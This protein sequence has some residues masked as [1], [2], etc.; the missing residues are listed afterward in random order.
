MKTNGGSG[1]IDHVFLTSGTSWRWVVSFTPRPLY[2][3]ER[4]SRT[5]WIGGWVG[6]T[7]GLDNMGKWKFLPPPGL[8]LRPLGLSARSQSLYQLHYPGSCTYVIPLQKC[9][10]YVSNSINQVLL[11]KLIV[12]LLLIKLIETESK[13][14]CSQEY[15]RT[16]KIPIS[17]T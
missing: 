2:S 9:V 14:P 6:P 7:A 13:L 15:A 11:E 3:R 12:A 17:Y 1:C 10:A 4:A 16:R 8:E 5:H